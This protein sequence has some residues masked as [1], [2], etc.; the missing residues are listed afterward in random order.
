MIY[1]L[2]MTIVFSYGGP[3]TPRAFSHTEHDYSSRDACQFAYR[4]AR[5]QAS[6]LA[7]RGAFVSATCLESK[8]P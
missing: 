4:I 1:T 3:S 7:E 6:K 2:I 8:K 5:E